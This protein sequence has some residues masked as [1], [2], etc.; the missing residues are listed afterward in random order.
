MGGGKLSLVSFSVKQMRTKAEHK[1]TVHLD[2]TN[3]SVLQMGSLLSI[4]DDNGDTLHIFLSSQG[5][6]QLRQTI[7][8][9][10]LQAVD[11]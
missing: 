5:W 3:V 4:T 2:D 11:S 9:R 6:E 8:Q 1:L 7:Q 10:T